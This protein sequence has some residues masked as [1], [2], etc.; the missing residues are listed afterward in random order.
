MWNQ[1]RT[2]SSIGNSRYLFFDEERWTRQVI[3]YGCASNPSDDTRRKTVVTFQ[4][5]RELLLFNEVPPSQRY[6]QLLIEGAVEHNLESEYQK[7][8]AAVE[9]RSGPKSRANRNDYNYYD[10]LIDRS[11]KAVVVLIAMAYIY[12][13]AAAS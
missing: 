4:S 9:S 13:T 2:Q 1:T 10:N 7:W 6:L 3:L 12:W 8:L 5:R 11:S